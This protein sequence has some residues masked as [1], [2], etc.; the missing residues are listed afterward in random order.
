MAHT[1][2]SRERLR[3][4]SEAAMKSQEYYAERDVRDLE[5]QVIICTEIVSRTVCLTRE[6]PHST[7]R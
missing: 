6:R 7:I 3:A 4:I 1:F 5:R 2:L